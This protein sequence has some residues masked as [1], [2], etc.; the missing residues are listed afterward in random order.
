MN[1]LYY[2]LIV[3]FVAFFSSCSDNDEPEN[4][5]NA[6]VVYA[7]AVKTLYEADKTPA[8]TLSDTEGVYLA[9]AENAQI[10]YKFICNLIDDPD[11]NGK[12]VTVS[13]GDKGSLKI[14][15]ESPTLLVKGIYNSIIVD[16]K[17]YQ[18]YTLQIITEEMAE[19][20]HFG[21]GVPKKIE[22]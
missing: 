13:L 22:L 16:I 12:D 5:P 19:N 15:G 21:D 1:K 14:L 7:N 3:A 4:T 11:W 10:S 8:F 18:P 6:D 20:G 17:G 2:L 9:S